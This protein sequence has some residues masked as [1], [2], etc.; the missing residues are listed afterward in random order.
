MLEKALGMRI[1]GELKFFKV[2][3][4]AKDFCVDWR[5]QYESNLQL[6]LRRGLL[7]PFNYEVT[8]R[9]I[10]VCVNGDKNVR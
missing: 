1:N 5:P 10:T 9:I 8:V 4:D 2:K 7:Y 3:K 6:A